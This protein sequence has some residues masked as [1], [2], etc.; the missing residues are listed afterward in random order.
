MTMR[1]LLSTHWKFIMKNGLNTDTPPLRLE[2]DFADHCKVR[3]ISHLHRQACWSAMHSRFG[4]RAKQE[5][6]IQTGRIVRIRFGHSWCF[7]RLHSH[8]GHN[9]RDARARCILLVEYIFLN[10]GTCVPSQT[11]IVCVVA[12]RNTSHTN[13][14]KNPQNLFRYE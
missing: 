12:Y 10:L 4:V 14:E 8:N 9:E 11:V 5:G 13:P 1:K 6:P 3:L 2:L 7:N